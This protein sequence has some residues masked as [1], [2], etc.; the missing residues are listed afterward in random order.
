VEA[1]QDLTITSTTFSVHRHGK[2]SHWDQG[3]GGVAQEA[4]YYKKRFFQGATIVPRTFWFVWVT[5]SPLGF[6][7]QAPPLASD[8]RATKEGRKPYNQVHF[9][10]QVEGRFLYATLL[11][12]DLLP[13]GHLDFRLVVLPIEPQEKKYKLLNAAEAR[14]QGFSHLA[15]WLMKAEDKWTKL[16]G[17]KAGEM[18]VYERIDRFRGLSRQDSQLTYRVAYI[19]SGTILTAALFDNKPVIFQVNGQEIQA[20]GFLADHVTFYFETNNSNEGYYLVSILNAPFVDELIKPMQSRG[21][22]GPRDIHKKVLELPIPQF[23]ADNPLH[24]RL[25]ALGEHCTQK[26][27]AW[28]SHGGPGQIKS[29]GRLRQMV[30]QLVKAE[31]SE[32]DG[33]VKEILKI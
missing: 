31:L 9:S 14:K 23:E 7:P 16:R 3:I 5:P 20:S 2:R 28:L 25:A 10:G 27:Q 19:K 32:L 15:Q 12:T 22:W 29:I 26:V 24:Q 13:F 17:A 4:S 8:P 6:N 18:N 11:S 30:R 33:I 21:L 1:D